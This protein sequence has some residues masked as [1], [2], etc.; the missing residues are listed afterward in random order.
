MAEDE[1]PAMDGEPHDAM[2]AL[3][4]GVLWLDDND[5]VRRHNAAFRRLLGLADT[6]DFVGRC[7]DEL[8]RFLVARGDYAGDGEDERVLAARL[9]ALKDGARP[10]LERV[11][12]DGRVLRV[13]AQRLAS[14]G[15]LFS[16]LDVTAERRAQEALRRKSRATMLALANL[17]EHRD[18]DT[19]IHVL[20]VSRLSYQVARELQRR[21]ACGGVVDDDFVERI[22]VASILHDVGKIATP[23]QVLRKPGMLE[24]VERVTMQQHT[25]TGD[26]LLR[27]ASLLMGDDHYLAM[28]AEIALTHH[29]WYDG[30]GYPAGLAGTAIPLAG[31]I[32]AVADVYDALTSRRP[33]KEPW[34][35]SQALALL[36]EQAGSQFD[37]EV[38][39]AFAAVML[40][41]E[42]VALVRWDD[43]MSIGDAMVD[44]QHK[45]LVD[46]INLLASVERQEDR[47]LIGMVIDELVGYAAFHFHYEEE[48]FAA[49]GYEDLERHRRIHQQ[50]VQWITGV[51]E[52]FHGHLQPQVGGRIL[53]WL[54]DWLQRHILGED[55][56]FRARQDACLP[57][58]GRALA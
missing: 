40:E 51:R 15:Y 34:S 12:P 21:G 19:G 47:V 9:A 4:Q 32:C 52:E 31:R 8:F 7:I 45:V 27:Q 39:D 10:H 26:K 48:L 33:Y 2:E 23:D 20:R 6:D 58:A 36:R 22:G 17:A 41:R 24:C 43:A 30:R 46:T 54:R 35:P 49:A 37:P 56:R 18:A 1:K 50:F 14:G 29:E 42:A 44:E 53:S 28:G 57:R 25:V 13:S 38:V 11:R 55:M 16:L 3:V 5:V